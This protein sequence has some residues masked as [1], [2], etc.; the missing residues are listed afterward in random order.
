M[1]WK[2]E[3]SQFCPIGQDVKPLSLG[4]LDVAESEKDA[5]E[6]QEELI[7]SARKF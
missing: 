3:S 1:N 6:E 5:L 4:R 7:K 2:W